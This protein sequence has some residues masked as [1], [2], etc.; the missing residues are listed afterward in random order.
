LICSP[1]FQE[2]HVLFGDLEVHVCVGSHV[3][4]LGCLGQREQAELEVVADGQLRHGD[5][6]PLCRVGDLPVADQFC[7]PDR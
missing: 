1:V 5:A 6:I 3:F 4:G 7:V 2:F